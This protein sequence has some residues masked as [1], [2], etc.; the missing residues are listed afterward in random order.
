MYG[1]ETYSRLGNASLDR[2]TYPQSNLVLGQRGQPRNN[3]I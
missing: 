2:R 3:E 1:V